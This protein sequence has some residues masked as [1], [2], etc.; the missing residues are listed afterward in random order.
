MKIH[1]INYH[2]RDK[3]LS[4]CT[5][6][7]SVLEWQAY[8]GYL[9]TPTG[10]GR[11]PYDRQDYNKYSSRP[12]HSQDYHELLLILRAERKFFVCDT[13]FEAKCGDVIV[14]PPDTPHAGIDLCPSPYERYYLYFHPDFFD[15]IPG[16]DLL[17][18]IFRNQ[19]RFLISFQP[20]ERD[21]ILT[22]LSA[23]QNTAAL[24]PLD[25]IGL[26]A[27]I[28]DFLVRLNRRALELGDTAPLE[29]TAPPLLTTIVQYINA[30]FASIT[31]IES[32]AEKFGISRAYMSK[33]FREELQISPYQYLQSI[34]LNEAQRLL[35]KGASVTEAC[36][37]AGFNDCSRF[38]SY[39]R[40]A[41]GM[42]P[43][44]YLHR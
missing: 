39:F 29:S 10:Y 30:E 19:N 27:A 9:N 17:G 1:S 11:P 7:N 42:T 21:R 13:V 14:F 31:T 28:L 25:R 41:V 16:G 43:G 35:K 2:V 20:E 22:S 23:Y 38:I 32:V 33:L 24:T 3:H 6:F 12:Y 8:F 26:Q 37:K 15:H 40:R 4:P 34:R 5:F 44:E 36:F 18:G